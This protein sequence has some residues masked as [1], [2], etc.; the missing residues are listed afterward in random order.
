MQLAHLSSC[1]A[2]VPHQLKGMQN[3]IFS[4]HRRLCPFVFV[5]LSLGLCVTHI[6]MGAQ[7]QRATN[8]DHAQ[9][10][11]NSNKLASAMYHIRNNPHLPLFL[12]CLCL[13]YY[14]YPLHLFCLPSKKAIAN[15]REWKPS[16]SFHSHIPF[17]FLFSIISYDS[18]PIH[19]V[20]DMQRRILL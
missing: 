12:F 11:L 17:H 8:R 10:K 18:L 2:K 15:F 1:Y 5:S 9:R 20:N 13:I 6:M 16:H 14:P 7:W 4:W 3:F 19:C